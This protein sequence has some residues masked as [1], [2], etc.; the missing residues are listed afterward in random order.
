MASCIAASGTESSPGGDACH[1]SI[2]VN[3]LIVLVIN[4]EPDRKREDVTAFAV[5][6]FC[7]CRRRAFANHV[8]IR[9]CEKPVS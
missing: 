5:C 8:E 4:G 9:R 3:E 7:F 6:I 1:L 2:G